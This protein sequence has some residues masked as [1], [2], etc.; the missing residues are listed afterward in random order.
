MFLKIYLATIVI[1]VLFYLIFM[2]RVGI[3]YLTYTTKE[4]RKKVNKADHS[5]FPFRIFFI[6]F[7]PFL[8]VILTCVVMFASENTIYDG[9]WEY[10]YGLNIR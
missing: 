3:A 7:T 6:L 9:I 10:I 2:I 4:L 1:S 5:S 8:N